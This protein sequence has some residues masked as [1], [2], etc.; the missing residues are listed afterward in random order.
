M[1]DHIEFTYV[2][3]LELNKVTLA[4]D[5]IVSIQKPKATQFGCIISMTNGEK[6]PVKE[7]YDDVKKMI[8]KD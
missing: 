5:Q 3:G 4:V 8:W 6:F 2:G 7:L 1:S